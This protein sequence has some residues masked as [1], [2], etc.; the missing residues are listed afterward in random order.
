MRPELI[1]PI[2]TLLLLG[3]DIE[4]RPGRRIGPRNVDDKVTTKLTDGAPLTLD[5]ERRRYGSDPPS[6]Q[7]PCA[8]HPTAR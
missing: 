3:E 1:I 5:E 6:G 8:D 2:R 4:R 7:Y